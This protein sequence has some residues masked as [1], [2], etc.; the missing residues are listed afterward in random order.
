[1]Q[2]PG[3][4]HFQIFTVHGTI[5]YPHVPVNTARELLQR[6]LGKTLIF[7]TL[8]LKYHEQNVLYKLTLLMLLKMI[9]KIV[10]A[11]LAFIISAKATENPENGSCTCDLSKL[12]TFGK[13]PIVKVLFLL[14][15]VSIRMLW[16]IIFIFQVL[17]S[18]IINTCF[19]DK[20]S[21]QNAIFFNLYIGKMKSVTTA[22]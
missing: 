8:L 12:S 9:I 3:R 11:H 18:D 20:I 5:G 14:Q 21:K 15:S 19:Q 17:F 1:M 10:K 6:R 4:L 2:P 7:V 16:T 13:S 22:S